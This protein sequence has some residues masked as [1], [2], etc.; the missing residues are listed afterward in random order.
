LLMLEFDGDVSYY[1]W[2]LF[3]ILL[4]T[5]FLAHPSLIFP[6]YVPNVATISL[7]TLSYVLT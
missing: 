5:S 6:D 2:L 4:L 3:L 1:R 7:K